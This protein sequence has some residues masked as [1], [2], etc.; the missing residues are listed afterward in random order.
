MSKDWT[1]NAKSVFTCHG[2]SSHS[3]LKRIHNDYYATEPK[4]VEELLRVESFCHQIWEPACGEGHM[5]Q[6]LIDNGYSVRSTDIV[7]RG[8]RFQGG[9]ENFLLST[10]KNIKCDIITNPPYRFAKEFV[11]KALDTVAEGQKVAMFLKL[12]FLESQK[13]GELLDT[14][15]P[16]RIYVARKRLQCARNGDFNTYKKGVGAAIC[17]AWFV[18]EKGFKGK[19]TI[20]Y[21]NK[22]DKSHGKK[23]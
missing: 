2:A 11:E 12:T 4:A 19:P 1:G 14:H 18:W 22:G 21:I 13:R 23:G 16:K 6:V 9:V 7:D 3:D 20:D 8:Y 5:S 15:P 17:Y 10:A